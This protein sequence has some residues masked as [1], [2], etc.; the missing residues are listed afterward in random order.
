VTGWGKKDPVP[1]KK[2][3]FSQSRIPVAAY[4]HFGLRHDPFT[5]LS[6]RPHNLSYFVGRERE[7]DR[8]S[9]S[10][11]A[12][13]N[14][15]LAG[16]A[17]SGKS[18]LLQMA[19]SRV[20]NEYHAVSIGSPKDDPQYF[21][22]ELLR[23]LLLRLPRTGI[24]FSKGWEEK[25]RADKQG[26]NSLLSMVRRLVESS[27]KPI[28]VFADDMEK[29]QGDR[30]AHWTRSERTLQILEELKPVFELPNVAFA[31]SLQDEFYGKVRDVVRDGADPTVLGLFKTVVHLE[32]FGQDEL[33]HLAEVRLEESGFRGNVHRF[34]EP[35]ALQLALS[36]SHGNP[37]RFLFLLS[38]ALDRSFIRRGPQVEFLDLFEAVN[39]HLRLDTVC[40]KLLFFLAKSGRVMAS[41]GDLQAFLGMDA[42]S[43]N[44][45][46][47]ILVKNRLADRLDVSGG[48]FVYGLPGLAVEEAKDIQI[49]ATLG[50]SAPF[51][52]EKIYLL[53]EDAGK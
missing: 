50:R 46:F 33:K 37:R 44:R 41:N 51:K 25:L 45:R 16:E 9:A 39:E 23:E 24:G 6:L 36:L 43:L 7:V 2:A 42:V 53:D 49:E 27:K 1:R 38:E 13:H 4:Q 31:V 21:L 14:V 47:E 28:L 19:R 17:G 22:T 10:L 48:S 40:R 52:D 34:F 15:G 3:H 35:E 26:K 8:M 32:P 18:S 12:L 30:V 29:I 20:T 5:T 11:F